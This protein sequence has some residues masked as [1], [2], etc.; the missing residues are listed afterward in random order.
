MYESVVF[1]YSSIVQELEE[2]C[3]NPP[4]Q[5]PGAGPVAGDLFNWEAI[6]TGT[7]GTPYEG[8]RWKLSIKFP[9]EYP[10][11]PPV[12]IFKTPIKHLNITREGRI[13]LDYLNTKWTSTNSINSSLFSSFS[14]KQIT[15]YHE[16]L[17]KICT[18]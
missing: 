10:F 6:L 18:I 17:G 12:V 3:R 4:A 2:M 16:L 7:H 8:G 1:T 5:C 9:S 15:F 14:S 11:K 13:C